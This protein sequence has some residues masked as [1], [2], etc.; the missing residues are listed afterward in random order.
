MLKLM[1]DSDACELSRF[2]RENPFGLAVCSAA[3]LYGTDCSFCNVWL[4]YR[5][6]SI[7]SA[8]LKLD[9]AITLHLSNSSDTDE[10]LEFTRAVGFTSLAWDDRFTALLGITPDSREDI[11]CLERFKSPLAG[12]KPEIRICSRE[13]DFR[14]AFALMF[15]GER[16]TRFDTWYTDAAARMNSGSGA[17]ESIYIDGKIVCVAAVS[18]ESEDA[19]MLSGIHT[20]EEYRGNGLASALVLDLA[21]KLPNKK[22]YVCTASPDINGFYERLGFSVCSRRAQCTQ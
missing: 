21:E 4:E 3:R 20:K 1:T 5:N 15:E 11:L 10:V 7:V 8:V 12:N 6:E 2:C 18:A 9:T 16:S 17:L 22:I 19:A 14:D 13:A